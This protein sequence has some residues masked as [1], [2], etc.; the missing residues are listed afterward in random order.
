MES[1]KHLGINK[2]RYL[3]VLFFCLVISC[4]IIPAVFSQNQ[5]FLTG[6]YNNYLKGL[7]LA[8]KGDYVQAIQ[9][10]R[11]AK[12]KD[13]DSV[14][15]RLKIATVLVRWGKLEE[16]EKELKEAKKIDSE[17]LDIS[18][19]LILVYSY[20]GKNKELEETYQEFL[21]KA[22]QLKPANV[23]ISEYL[24]QFYFYKK[25][26]NE[27]ITIYEKILENN[28][29]YVEAFLWLGYLYDD[30]GNRNKAIA[31]WKK[32]L[33]KDSEYAPILNSLGYIYAEEEMELDLA[34]SMI[35]KALQ[36]EPENGA[37]LDSL[38]WVYFKK[39]DLKKAQDY[40]V[41]AIER[42]KDPDVYEHLGDL[43]VK[44]KDI[45]KGVGYYQEGL[46]NFPEDKDLQSKVKEYG[47]EDKVSKREGE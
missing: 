22:H 6:L 31:I 19:A 11:K 9:E 30:T 46:L 45:Q 36:K 44:L 5:K 29:D 16:A 1:L 21:E 15:I 14:Y 13:P 8:E 4:L 40:L 26:P 39:G 18:L 42:I 12:A 25:R 23:G 28:P 24:A 27:A 38:G 10:L 2:L 41:K 35:K 7:F 43:Y 34:E 47:K 17:S 3:T 32:G 20:A 37:Y 33:E